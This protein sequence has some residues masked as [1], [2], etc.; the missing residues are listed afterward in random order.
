MIPKHWLLGV[1]VLALAVA[2]ASG[3][4][5]GQKIMRGEIA[6]VE[7]A[8]KEAELEA[9]NALANLEQKN[10]LLAQSLEDAAY[11]VPDVGPQCLTTDRVRRLNLR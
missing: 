3:Y 9:A 1:A 8:K 5:T 4:A 6:A 11:A 7:L 10:R 2:F